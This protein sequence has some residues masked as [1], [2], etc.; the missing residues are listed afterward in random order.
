[1][2]L[3]ITDSAQSKINQVAD[4]DTR[5]LLSFDDGV[6]PFS[7][8]GICSLETAFDVIAVD[9]DA[10][11]P[12]YEKSL[13]TNH[14]EWAYKGYSKNYLDDDMKLDVV[15]NNLV[16]SGESGILDSAVTLKRVSA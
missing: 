1:M 7:K 3:T 10:L 8:W 14:G 13:S 11:T 9:K 2:K 16:L 12:D 6:G 15:N 5:L 4:E